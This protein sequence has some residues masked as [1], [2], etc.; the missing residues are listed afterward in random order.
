MEQV[1]VHR[2]VEDVSVRSASIAMVV[3]PCVGHSE[4]HAEIL[5]ADHLSC[6]CSVMKIVWV[7]SML[8][9]PQMYLDGDAILYLSRN[10]VFFVLEIDEHISVTFLQVTVRVPAVRIIAHLWQSICGCLIFWKSA[11]FAHWVVMVSAA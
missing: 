1:D 4:G 9:S 3:L 2:H 10:E 8:F 7:P 11:V 6:V 5:A